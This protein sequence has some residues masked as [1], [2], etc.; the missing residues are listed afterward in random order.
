MLE[1]LIEDGVFQKEDRVA[2]GVSGGAD[3]MVL[4]WALIDK[5]KEVGFYLH[6][7]NVN[8]HIRGEESNQDS[9]FVEDFCKKKKIPCEVVDVDVV[10]LKKS[11]KL[12]LEESARNARYEVFENVMKK[13]NLNKLALA[14]HKNDQAETILMH[15]F[16]GS[17]IAG[18][19]GIRENEKIVRPLLKLSKD[20]ILKIAKEHG[21]QFV[22]DSTNK[23]NDCS[24]NFLR[25][26]VFPEI[27]K[28]YPN[29]VDGL[30]AFGKRC[31]EIQKFI[32]SQ[33]NENLFEEKKDGL[34]LLSQAFVGEK[35]VVRERI[36]TAFVKMGIFQDIEAKH[37]QMI[38]NLNKLETNKE[39]SL[40]HKIQARKVQAGIKFFK[41]G[42]KT[43]QGAVYEFEL[44][45]IEF[46]GYGKIEALL[47]NSDDVVYGEGDLFL[48]YSKISNEAVW[49]TRKLGDVFA[50]LGTGSKK[51]NDYFTDKK[52]DVDARDT[53][54]IL[55][56]N[57]NV[58]LV[59]GEDVSE[60]AKI[61]GE[62]DQ[63]VK[64][65][66][67]PNW[68]SWHF[69]KILPILMIGE[70]TMLF[71]RKF[72]IFKLIGLALVGAV[73]L[74]FVFKASITGSIV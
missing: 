68:N 29:S 52:I 25:N 30:F 33:V 27:L 26:V 5:Q 57:E 62:T 23:E 72:S 46:E 21:I 43:E 41:E 2:V 14:H 64:I 6:V 38:A 48:D 37:Y 51:L 18:A 17:G 60:C 8:H 40:P 50:K 4:L 36:K 22:E 70:K 32:E 59:A 67:F 15:I 9:A 65:K 39:I 11:D 61:D 16:R 54:P 42:S 66:F 44:G 47:V 74:V 45:T 53:I 10:G 56:V 31:E 12:T 7:V 28:V 13:N 20:D 58:L 73:V 63:I 1:F 69:V 19:C 24:R 55:A 3:S 49:R 71:G 34:I 35:F